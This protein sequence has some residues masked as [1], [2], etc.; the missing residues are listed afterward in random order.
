[1]I[2][3]DPFHTMVES[4]KIKLEYNVSTIAMQASYSKNY[5][6]G[7]FYSHNV[8]TLKFCYRQYFH[9]DSTTKS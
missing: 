2:M 5:K 3:P 6:Y 7:L 4:A 1:M 8:T 9:T